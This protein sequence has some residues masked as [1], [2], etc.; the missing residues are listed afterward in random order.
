MSTE[1]SS[2]AMITCECPHCGQAYP[3][4]ED[5][6][7]RKALCEACGERFMVTSQD[8]GLGGR[9]ASRA[10]SGPPL[11]ALASSRAPAP[12][13]WAKESRYE[14][15]DMVARGGMGGDSA[16]PRR[17]YPSRRGHEGHA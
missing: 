7:G 10:E 2:G 8:S 4:S 17:E 13:G 3:V 12:A 15:G 5:L 11:G 14:I 16:G 6:L 9:A 1:D